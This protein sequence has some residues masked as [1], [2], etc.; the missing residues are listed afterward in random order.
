MQQDVLTAYRTRRQPCSVCRPEIRGQPWTILIGDGRA[1]AIGPAGIHLADNLVD[2]RDWVMAHGARG[3]A[4]RREL[5][6]FLRRP[7][8]APTS[9]ARDNPPSK[10]ERNERKMTNQDIRSHRRTTDVTGNVRFPVDS[11]EWRNTGEGGMFVRLVVMGDA[12]LPREQFYCCGGENYIRLDERLIGT[13]AAQTG[14]LDYQDNWR[15][16]A[17]AR[18]REH[19][20][21]FPGD[22]H[23]SAPYLAVLTLGSTGWSGYS[24]RKGYWL[25]RQDDLTAEGKT[26][27]AALKAAYPQATLVL[28]TWLDT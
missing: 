9:S 21:H 14:K 27:Y 5:L 7:G 17:A 15:E 16:W 23:V 25:C 3:I 6:G 13:D 12:P 22:N 19:N 11:P 4:C 2:A 8:A 28:Q 26:L 18:E 24:E 20:R 10:S 1:S